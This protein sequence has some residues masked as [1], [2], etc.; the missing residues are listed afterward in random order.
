MEMASSS[1]RSEQDGVKEDRCQKAEKQCLIF[2]YCSGNWGRDAK[3]GYITA[4]GF[5]ENGPSGNVR[6]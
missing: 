3:H 5:V 1:C 2:R 4:A 6:Q